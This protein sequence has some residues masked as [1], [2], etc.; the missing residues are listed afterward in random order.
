MPTTVSRPSHSVNQGT[1]SPPHTSPRSS[2]LPSHT[3][4]GCFPHG[5]VDH[6]SGIAAVA[7]LT[8]GPPPAPHITPPPPPVHSGFPHGVVDHVSDIA[9]VAKRAGACLHVDACLGGF[10]L[11]F[12]R[13]LG[14]KVGERG[15]WAIRRQCVRGGQI[16]CTRKGLS[17]CVLVSRGRRAHR[18]VCQHAWQEPYN[19][20]AS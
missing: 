13:Q 18:R 17:A 8:S 1:N 14:Y 10:V 9:A 7:P 19:P 11:P 6:V 16:N 5:V 3:L 20:R 15:L 2:P 4:S 12:A